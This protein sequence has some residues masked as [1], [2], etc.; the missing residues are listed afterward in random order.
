LKQTQDVQEKTTIKSTSFEPPKKEESE[1]SDQY[2]E[3]FE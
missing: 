3:D 1:G 2:D